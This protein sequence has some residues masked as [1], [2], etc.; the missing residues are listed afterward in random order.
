M[1]LLSRCNIEAHKERPHTPPNKKITL[2]KASER[3]LHCCIESA[4]CH[5]NKDFGACIMCDYGVGRNLAPGE[6]EQALCQSLLPFQGQIDTLLVGTYGSIFDRKEIPGDCFGVILDFLKTFNV[7]N[8]IFETHCST[9]TPEILE[10][11]ADVVTDKNIII[12]MGYESCDEYILKNC[13]NKFLDL[14]QLAGVIELVHRYSMEVCLNVFLGAPFLCAADQLDS[15][16][17]S[18]KWA[19]EHGADSVVLF[20]A[21]IKP[22]TLLH[23]LYLKNVYQP[24]SQWMLVE[25]LSR[26][27]H[28]KL[29]RVSLSW[30][31][32][33]ENFY[34]NHQYPLIPPL[35]CPACHDR[36]FDFYR[37]FMR[38]CDIQE[39]ELLLQE[40]R[41]AKQN[42]ECR[43][44]FLQSLCESKDRMDVKQ[45][46]ALLR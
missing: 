42:C 16:A 2:W 6:L 17:Y 13:L 21:N 3:F 35:D 45:I 18:V 15:A 37:N 31:G 33:R 34:E 9:V 1:N 32:D 27:P 26:V 11:I 12:E 25:L 38:T 46:E 36:I 40:I 10:K 8:V 4:G 29:N 30:Y 5:M 24:V 22:F 23:E 7:K 14:D 43:E 20:P 41:N 44:N 28:E 19:F 39:R